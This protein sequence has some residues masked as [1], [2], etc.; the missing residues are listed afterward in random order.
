MA[1]TAKCLLESKYAENAQ[2]SQYTAGTGIRAIVDKFTGYNGTAGAVTLTVNLVASGGAAGA[3]N[4]KVVKSL[5]AGETYS[6]PELVGQ[7]L[8]TGDFISTLAGAATS[9]V[10]RVSGREVS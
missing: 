10:I 1:V 7:V 4:I 6:F 3:A 8:N 9:I 5:A 2:T